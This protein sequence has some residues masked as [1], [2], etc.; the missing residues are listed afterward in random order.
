LALPLAALITVDNEKRLSKAETR[1]EQK[2]KKIEQLEA[3]LKPKE[4]EDE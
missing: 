3:K 2:L 1:I 4:N